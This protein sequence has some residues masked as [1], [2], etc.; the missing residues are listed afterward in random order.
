M[1]ILLFLVRWVITLPVF[2]AEI[3]LKLILSIILSIAIF[4]MVVLLPIFR[5]KLRNLRFYYIY[6][7]AYK[8]KGYFP[9]TYYV[10]KEWN[11]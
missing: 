4:G 1:K 9:I 6:D 8:W 10:Y 11:G 5:N 2:A 3:I 7:Y